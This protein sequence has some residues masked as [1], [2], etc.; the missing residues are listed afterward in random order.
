MRKTASSPLSLIP[1]TSVAASDTP[2]EMTKPEAPVAVPVPVV[3]EGFDD[4]FEDDLV[5]PRYAIVQPTSHEGTPGTF[6]SNLSGE[7][8]QELQLVPLRIQRGRVL[9][10]DTLGEDPVCKSTDGM[11]PAP[12]IEKSVNDACCVLAGRRL[13]PICPMATWQRNEPPKCRDTYSM[14]GLDLETQTP[15]M[16]AFHGTGIRAVRVLRTMIFQRRLSLFDA[17]C[18]LRLRKEQNGKGAYFV[19]EFVDVRQV[20]PPGKHREMY[21][22]FSRYDV[23][24]TFEA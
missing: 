24:G 4:L 19:P 9:W 20:D 12:V 14:I 22:Q 15:V 13:R 2:T 18:T 6:R 5:I 1:S 23:E 8:R 7:E 3:P 10:S 21:E 16:L 11:V 17:T